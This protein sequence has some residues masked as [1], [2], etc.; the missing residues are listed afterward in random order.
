MKKRII[1]VEDS[2]T[3]CERIC[4]MLR[5]QGWEASSAYNMCKGMELVQEADEFTIVLSDLRLPDGDGIKL[6]EWMRDNGYENKFVIMTGYESYSS[7]VTAIKKRGRQL[8]S[9]EP[10][11][12]RIVSF[13]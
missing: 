4:I 12:R 6:L 3:F 1:V 9:K 2:M 7:A 8:F 10:N 11:A 5:R 13:S